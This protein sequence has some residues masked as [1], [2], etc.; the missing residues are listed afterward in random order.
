[1]RFP[2]PCPHNGNGWFREVLEVRRLCLCLREWTKELGK[3]ARWSMAQSPLSV[4]LSLHPAPSM[5]QML[6]KHS[7]IVAALPLTFPSP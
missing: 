7:V 2:Q 1:M 4:L 3:S 6:D 5:W